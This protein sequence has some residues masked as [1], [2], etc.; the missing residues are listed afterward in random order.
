MEFS[1]TTDAYDVNQPIDERLRHFSSAGFPYAHWS[2]HWIS[3]MF[4]TKAYAEQITQ[5]SDRYDI[6]I[7]NIHG[8]CRFDGGR[9]FTEKQWY[10]LTLQRYLI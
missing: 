7:Q 1:M 6:R 3:D 8:V 9:P 4:Y 10:Q 5:L 2:E